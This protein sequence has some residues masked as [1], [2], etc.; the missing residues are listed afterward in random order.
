MLEIVILM[1]WLLVEPIVFLVLFV[2]LLLDLIV[3][4]FIGLI[5]GT[6]PVVRILG[7]VVVNG[8]LI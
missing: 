1:R 7:V 2:V 3:I 5:F 4:F 8:L 6:F